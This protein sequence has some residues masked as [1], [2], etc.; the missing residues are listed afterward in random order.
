MLS[1]FRSEGGGLIAS[2]LPYRA[3]IDGLRAIAVLLVLVYHYYPQFIPGGF[4][5][6]DV[7][8][9]IS[10]YLITGI[11]IKSF[12]NGTFSIFGFYKRRILRIFPGLIF[13]FIFSLVVGW[14]FF[15]SSDYSALGK[16]VF[17]SAFFVQNINLLFESGYFDAS[18]IEKPLLHLWSLAVEEQFYVFFPLILWALIKFR[19]SVLFFV[20]I[21]SFLSFFVNIIYLKTGFSSGAYFSLF[22]RSWEIFAGSMVAIAHASSNSVFFKR[23]GRFFSFAGFLNKFYFYIFGVFLIFFG[24]FF[25]SQNNFPG[26]W[27]LIP[28]VG[29]GLVIGAGFSGNDRFFNPL[30][31]KVLVSI[32]KISYPLYL[33]HWVL[34]SFYVIAFGEMSAPQFFYHKLIL[35]FFSFFLAWVTYFFLEKPLRRSSSGCAALILLLLSGLIGIY[36][37]FVYLKSGLPQVR[38]YSWAAENRVQNYLKSIDRDGRQD[39]CFDLLPRGIGGEDGWYCKLGSVSS[40]KS[41]LVYGD[42]H[43]LSLLPSIDRY[44]LENNYKIFFAGISA[45]LPLVGFDNL[46]S[47]DNCREL[48]ERALDLAVSQKVKAVVII[49]NW[50]G[51]AFDSNVNGFTDKKLSDIAVSLDKTLDFFSQKNTPVV[52]V[53]DN[54]IQ[55]GILP[56]SKLRYHSNSEDKINENSIQRKDHV[57]HQFLVNTVLRDLS[58]KYKEVTI[59]NADDLLCNDKNCP[60]VYGGEFMYYDG[61]HLSLAGAKRVYPAMEKHLN[62]ILD[63]LD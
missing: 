25:T 31:S 47:K 24:G 43:A 37:L 46:I 60:W 16:H 20:F 11:L 44:G 18:S 5:G 53:E 48:G 29:A 58:F 28:V 57:Q 54:P 33:W 7:F 2:N 10:G 42:S 45:C 32:G 30:S 27:A 15:F 52:L 9:V 26:F 17:F 51:Y 19:L 14:F 63:N 1:K 13:V 36:G 59:L 6:V 12:L 50:T 39:V 8:F 40:R 38:S 56:K 35:I 49:Q 21:I 23:L 22:S 55:F 62:K 61:G 41:I 4:I 34:L 3:D